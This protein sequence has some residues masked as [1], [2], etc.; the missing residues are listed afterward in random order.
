MKAGGS[1]SSAT[2]LAMLVIAGSGTL[3]QEF[4][5]REKL[6]AHSSEFSQRVIQVTEGVYVA[7]GHS[8]SNVILVQGD[9][10]SQGRTPR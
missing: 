8:A 5:G 6:R 2:A 7:V 9:G 4:P 10:G 3:A 1:R